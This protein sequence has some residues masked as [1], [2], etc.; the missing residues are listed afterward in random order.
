MRAR[1]LDAV[2]SLVDEPMGAEL[3]GIGE[4]VAV[5]SLRDGTVA[6]VV[7]AGFGELERI[8]EVLGS[9]VRDTRS[10][11][12]KLVVVGGD[13]R[14]RAMLERLQPAV[15]LGR[16]IQVF[17]LGGDGALWVG[18]R[19]RPDSPVGAVLTAV[20]ARAEPRAI[21]PAA[22][23]AAVHRPT[24][25][26]R[27]HAE[28]VHAFVE[29]TRR[30]RPVAT[31]TMIGL[32]GVVFA[33]QW[34]W[35]GGEY[36]PTMVRMGANTDAAFA[37]EPWRLLSCAWLHAG[38]L[39][40]LVNGYV[41]YSLGGFLERLLGAPRLVVLYAA[42][43]LG[44]GLASASFS[45][46]LL[47]VGA[48]G[49]IWGL[50]GASVALAWRPAGLI[51]DAVVPTVRRNAMVNIVINLAV[52]FLPQI[53][54]MAHIGGGLVGAGLV[55][56]GVVTRGVTSGSR[57]NPRAWRALAVVAATVMLAAPV[58]AIA[59]GRP[60]AIFAEGT[61]TRALGDGVTIT[62][63]TALEAFEVRTEGARMEAFVGDPL[64]DRGAMTIVIEPHGAELDSEELE[65]AFAE[66][67]DATIEVPQGGERVGERELTEGPRHR[68]FS[69]RFRFENGLEM[70]VVQQLHTTARAGFELMYWASTP[71][72]GVELRAAAETV[73]MP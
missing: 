32:V 3:L 45:D 63:P 9:F 15:M 38:V 53:D 60:W 10:T 18:A 30:G 58:V 40:L 71:A 46:A 33:L 50:L 66:F 47:S 21:D 7:S 49:A 67:Q 48:S 29:T 28:D 11:D 13:E 31:L 25:A 19:S 1:F 72:V 65:L 6:M 39:H 69:E 70:V 4:D 44:G 37:G 12:I 34:L 42:A 68:S 16:V 24:A 22:L 41:L 64:R 59:H 8:A 20:G 17:A 57:S 51:P 55:L 54:I 36:L 26:E 43:A 56:S 62:V 52:S 14:H 5:A 35:G 23:A 73:R 27:A 2:A 61:D